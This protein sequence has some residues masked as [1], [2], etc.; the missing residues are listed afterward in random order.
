MI[1]LFVIGVWQLYE[2]I[3]PAGAWWSIPP[4]LLLSS[5][6]INGAICHYLFPFIGAAIKAQ[7]QLRGVDND[8]V[9]TLVQTMLDYLRVPY[10]IVLGSLILGSLWFAA[11]ILLRP[12]YFPPW[13][14]LLSPAF[15][16]GAAFLFTSIL[17]API[18]G[19]LF[20]PLVHLATPFIF[21]TSTVLLWNAEGDFS[22][23]SARNIL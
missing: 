4:F 19:Y 20:P 11:A 18:G 3:K 12:T 16:I 23:E 9:G 14:A 17:P 8:V 7:A 15:P 5:F 6:F 13:M 21:G 10:Y 22:E 2:G 1:P